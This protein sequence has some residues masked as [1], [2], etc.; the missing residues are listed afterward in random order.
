MNK[1]ERHPD[2]SEDY[3]NYLRTIPERVFSDAL[4][5]MYFGIIVWDT[6]GRV[7]YAN[8]AVKKYYEKA[9]GWL[10]AYD[11]HIEA[12]AD[13]LPFPENIQAS[14][15]IPP[16]PEM[17]PN[18]RLRIIT[19]VF[20]D[21]ERTR[22]AFVIEQFQENLPYLDVDGSTVNGGFDKTHDTQSIV[23]RSLAFLRPLIELKKIAV[24]NMPI[25]LL[26]ESGVGKTHIAE[27][28]HNCS[29]RKEQSFFSVNCGAIPENL[30]EA[31]LFGYVSGAFTD[32]SKTGKKGIFETARHGTVF[33]DEIGDMPLPLQVKI[34]HVIENKSFVPVGGREAMDADVRIITATNKNLKELIRKNQFRSDLYWRISTFYQTIPPLRERKEDIIP[35]AH[36]YLNQLNEKYTTDKVFDFSTLYTLLDYHWPG[37][38]RELKHV[39]ER[40]YILSR[41]SIISFPEFE[42]SQNAGGDDEETGMEYDLPFIVDS[43]K[44]Y[45]VK[46]SYAEHKTSSKVAKDLNI[47]QS[48]A[49][50]LIQRYCKNNR[51]PKK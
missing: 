51:N 45:L 22:I 2:H 29:P 35:L 42:M 25:L 23:G 26:G 13:K 24:S 37:N 1:K 21:R 48:K 15:V 14:M 40:M 34:L 41:N 33:L 18:V 11:E 30:L 19:P 44:G 36:F 16:E 17:N 8:P 43:I 20:A 5:K 4:E 49:Y 32:A 9:P 50:R 6:D 47:S 46:N 28:I 10:S 39:I 38:V 31:E 3:E 12:W 7:L 27:Y